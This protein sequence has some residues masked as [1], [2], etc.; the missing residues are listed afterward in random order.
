M[1]NIISHSKT[2]RTYKIISISIQFWF[3]FG[4][5]KQLAIIVQVLYIVFNQQLHITVCRSHVSN[6]LCVLEVLV[7]LY[8]SASHPTEPCKVY[9]VYTVTLCLNHM[10]KHLCI[11]IIIYYCNGI[12]R[13]Y[14]SFFWLQ[15]SL[16]NSLN[17]LKPLK[18]ATM[19]HT[20]Y[21]RFTDHLAALCHSLLKMWK[22]KASKIRCYSGFP[23]KYFV[24]HNLVC[25][26]IIIGQNELK[27]KKG[28]YRILS[29][30]C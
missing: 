6:R 25:Q 13:V 16:N 11:P 18:E 22:I 28:F 4:T 23:V 19:L 27:P 8:F 30:N 14:N 24:I 10:Q 1:R 2:W 9:L 26:R 3:R 5:W 15:Y 21:H 20:K 12:N 17:T 7:K 29:S